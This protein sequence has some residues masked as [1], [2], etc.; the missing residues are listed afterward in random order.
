MS[1][2]EPGFEALSFKLSPY[3]RRILIGRD[4]DLSDATGEIL[5][6]AVPTSG[7]SG[8]LKHSQLPDARA[9]FGADD[10][11]NT[12]KHLVPKGPDVSE[13]ESCSVLIPL[14]ISLEYSWAS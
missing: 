6:A 10:F 2:Q 5:P 8:A 1:R 13:A 3:L 4:C 14:S 9:G 11:I 7:T 12:H